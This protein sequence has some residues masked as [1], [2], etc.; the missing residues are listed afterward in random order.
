MPWKG[1]SREW[2]ELEINWKPTVRASDGAVYQVT[3]CLGV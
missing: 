1:V 3:R 2:S